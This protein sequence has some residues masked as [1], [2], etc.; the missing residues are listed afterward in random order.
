[1]I[2]CRVVGR[3]QALKTRVNA[4]SATMA[5]PLR[6]RLGN[7]N[8]RREASCNWVFAGKSLISVGF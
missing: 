7:D 8:A 4:S 1:L 6:T 3:E 2:C 5:E